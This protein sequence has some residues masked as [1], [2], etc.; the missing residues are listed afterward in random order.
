MYYLMDPTAATEPETATVV[1]S[2]SADAMCKAAND[3]GNGYL[4]AN[5][6]G[7]VMWGWRTDGRWSAARPTTDRMAKER[8][9]CV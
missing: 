9:P 6:E 1:G 4:V 3:W 2:G 7:K 5:D 8:T